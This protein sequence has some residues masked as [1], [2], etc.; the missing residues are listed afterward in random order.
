MKPSQRRRFRTMVASAA[1]VCAAATPDAT[2]RA[3]EYTVVSVA[4][5]GDAAPDSL[6]GRLLLAVEAP[7]I[8]ETGDIFFISHLLGAPSREGIFR[9][10]GSEIQP[11][12]LSTT[13]SFRDLTCSAAGG[14]AVD[15]GDTLLKVIDGQVSVIVSDGDPVPGTET[16]FLRP[17]LP[18]INNAGDVAFISS[19]LSTPPGRGGLFLDSNGEKSIVGLRGDPVPDREGEIFEA[20]SGPPR[21]NHA[22]NVTFGALISD[23]V[24]P[25]EGIFLRSPNGTRAVVLSTD[26]IPGTTKSYGSFGILGTFGGAPVNNLDHVAF[27]G[28]NL[29]SDPITRGIFVDVV[30]SVRIVARNVDETPEEA[31]A[32]F[33]AFGAPL[34]NDADEVAFPALIQGGSGVPVALYVQSDGNLVR[35]HQPDLAEFEQALPGFRTYSMNNAG[36]IAFIST[37]HGGEVDPNTCRRATRCGLFLALRHAELEIDIRPGST[38]NV[39]QTSSRGVVPVAILGSEEFDVRKVDVTTLAFGPGKASPIH[40]AG[41]HIQDVN[42]DGLPDLVS[43]YRTQKIGIAPEYT[44]ACVSGETDEAW[45]R[46]FEACDAVDVFAPH[47]GAQ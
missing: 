11:V 15:A 31:E 28:E 39:I 43:H 5:T 3:A 9:A 17:A 7:C 44:E 26:T 23:S 14:I 29:A 12:L 32:A 1:M 38:R 8:T 30:G 33:S 20:I 18:A 40:Q 24:N 42:G 46:P 2:P 16:E 22:G 13:E 34:I 21:I 6:G 36:D 25:I 37:I 10:S 4:V 47:G 19:V 45:R 35:I 27:A 41:G